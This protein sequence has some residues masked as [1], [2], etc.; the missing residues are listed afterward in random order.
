[1]TALRRRW[2]V[3]VVIGA[4]AALGAGALGWKAF[5][6]QPTERRDDAARPPAGATSLG[7]GTFQGAD[8]AHSASGRVT[9]YRAPEGA[10]LVFEGY[11]ATSGPRVHFYL[12]EDAGGVFDPSTAHVVPVPGG[13]DGD[14]A[15]LRGTFSVPVPATIDATKAKSV[16]VWCT[17]FGVTFGHARLGS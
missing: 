10:A 8:R 3:L 5:A 9:L 13:V 17:R 14:Q 15:T 11:E 4:L 16:I 7:S 12:S 6:P 2:T 1:M